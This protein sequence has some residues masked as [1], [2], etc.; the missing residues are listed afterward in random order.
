MTNDASTTDVQETPKYSPIKRGDRIALW[1]LSP[2]ISPLIIAIPMAFLLAWFYA[3]FVGE[4]LTAME[5]TGIVFG[6]S[7]LGG[8]P[9]MYIYIKKKDIPLINRKQAGLLGMTRSDGKFLLWY[10]P[11]AIL[12]VYGGRAVLEG[13]F[14][15]S[16]PYNQE[17]IQ[18]LMADIPVSLMFFTIVISAPIAEEW[19][20]RG[21]MLYKNGETDPTWKAVIA[22]SIW[23][24]LLHMPMDIPSAYVY[25]MMGFV[26]GYAV[27]RTNS[28]ETAITLHLLN[29]LVGFI[30]LSMM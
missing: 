12:A 19:L 2:I 30:A 3:N 9:M 1:V 23:F 11:L 16:V 15:A 5:L 28:I 8:L 20:F 26:L 10:T 4:G 14:G 24:G 27:K 21:V 18:S 6:V 17:T 7:S 29:N 13:I 25:F 22:S